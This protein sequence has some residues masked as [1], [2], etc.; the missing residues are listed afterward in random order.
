MGFRSYRPLAFDGQ[1]LASSGEST[2]HLH[3]VEVPVL[4]GGVDCGLDITIALQISVLLLLL[5]PLLLLVLLLLQNNSHLAILISY[6]LK[7]L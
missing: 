3:C 5:L 7:Q 1:I 6:F 4:A 2:D